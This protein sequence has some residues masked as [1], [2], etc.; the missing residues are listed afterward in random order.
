[1]NVLIIPVTCG[2]L[3]VIRFLSSLKQKVLEFKYVLVIVEL[4]FLVYMLNNLSLQLYV[5]NITR[6]FLALE[7]PA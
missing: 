1:M 7:R 6:L 3:N 4:L 2:L 5:N